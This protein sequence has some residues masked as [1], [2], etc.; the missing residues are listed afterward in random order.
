[1]KLLFLL[2]FPLLGRAITSKFGEEVEGVEGLGLEHHLSNY[3][4]LKTWLIRISLTDF[5]PWAIISR[6]FAVN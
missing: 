6:M 1:L 4:A 5:S 3:L 2:E